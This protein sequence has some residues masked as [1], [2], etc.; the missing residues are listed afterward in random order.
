MLRALLQVYRQ[1]QKNK[2]AAA[3][4][5]AGLAAA[6]AATADLMQAA[7][8]LQMKQQENLLQKI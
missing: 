8:T 2:D 4:I 7:K 5:A 3:P 1:Q 6:A